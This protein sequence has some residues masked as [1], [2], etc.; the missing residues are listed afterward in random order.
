MATWAS[1]DDVRARWLGTDALPDDAVI[2]AW[3]TDAETIIFAEYPELAARL[4]DDP[5]GSW[6]ARVVYVAVQLTIQALKNPDGV[7]QSARTS[8]PF[9]E[10]VTYGTETISGAMALTPAHRALLSGGR[11]RHVGIDMTAPAP[12]PQPLQNAWVNG[13]DH[14]APGSRT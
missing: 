11:A 1:P 3:I 4:T 6:R 2:Q 13:A 7:R 12:A 5:D 14:L 8:G 9:T 10:S